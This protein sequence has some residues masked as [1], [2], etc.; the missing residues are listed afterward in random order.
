VLAR[1]LERELVR[2]LAGDHEL[3]EMERAMVQV[4]LCRVPGYAA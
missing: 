4:A 2:S 3:A 1:K